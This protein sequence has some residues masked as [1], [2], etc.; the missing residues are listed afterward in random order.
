MLYLRWIRHF[1]EY[2]EQ[3]GLD[4]RA[5]LTRDGA[6]R[7]STW[8]VRRHGIRPE[9]AA[10]ARTALYALNRVDYVLGR[11]PPCWR[12][13]PVT[14]APSTALL[15]SYEEYLVTHRGSPA[16]TVHKKLTHIGYFLR[17][18][19]VHQRTWRSMKLTDVDAF[20][21]DC[22]RRYARATT[23]DIACSIRSFSRFLFATGRSSRNLAESVIAPVQPRYERPR[24]ALA[25]EHVQRLLA[26][27]DQSNPRGLR[28]YAMLLMMATYGFGAGELIRL[29]VDD[30][31]WA[32]STL[33]VLRPKTGALFTLP[34]LP[35][36]AKALV[37]YRTA[38]LDLTYPD[39][40]GRPWFYFPRFSYSRLDIASYTSAGT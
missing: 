1:R 21:V 34:L 9:T 16:A 37:R 36:V 18:L 40:S 30:I 27:V 20:F 33:Q 7:F 5:Q 6:C 4:E 8:Y 26:A 12:H 17:H 38:F 13:A 39:E 32:A 3:C 35:V 31:N 23:A 15:R 29:R 25:W 14:A 24:R 22:S 19:R 2:C 10:N 28:D 11:D